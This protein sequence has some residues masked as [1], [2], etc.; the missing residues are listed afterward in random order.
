[1]NPISAKDCSLI[2]ADILLANTAMSNKDNL[3]MVAMAAYHYSQA[4]EKSLK[5]IIKANDDK[6]PDHTHDIATLLVQTELCSPNFI[7]DH[8]FIAD[9]AAEL[10]AMNGLRYGDKAIRKGDVYV[11]MKE[12]Q[13]L[14]GELEQDLMK[15]ASMDK[16]QLQ[17]QANTMYRDNGTFLSLDDTNSAHKSH[18][19]KGLFSRE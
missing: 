15:S 12:A 9:N 7:T 1:M 14:Y 6:S 5:A 17:K 4:I 2:E 16:D 18:S 11:L 19:K 13:R 3:H 10:S 8:K